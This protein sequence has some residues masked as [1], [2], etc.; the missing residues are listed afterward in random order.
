MKPAW[1][2][3]QK[4]L[5]LELRSREILTS[6]FVFGLLILV[7]FN[8]AFEPTSEERLH[9]IPGILWI[10]YTFG[11]ILGLNR[12]LSLERENAGLESLSL[13]PINPSAIFLG[14]WLTNFIFMTLIQIIILPFLGLFF[15]ISL[16]PSLAS[17]LLV[18]LLGTAGFAATGTLFSALALNTRMRDVLLPIL[19]FPISIPMLIG[20]VECT[21]LILENHFHLNSTW[22]KL[23]VV[24]DII[25]M[26]TGT[27]LFEYVLEE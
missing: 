4:D 15:N 14:K 12:T 2:I 23:I 3:F 16:L 1:L 21:T 22:F 5:L 20:C 17:L 18:N 26:T 27:L 19:L 9:I 6:M 10:C 13:A 24:Y 11:G 8:F 7:L 25:F